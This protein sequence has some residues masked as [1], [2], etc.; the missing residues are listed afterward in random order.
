[1]KNKNKFYIFDTETTG[2]SKDAQIIGIALMTVTEDEEPNKIESTLCKSD[3]FI[4][5]FAQELHHITKEDIED[6]P[7]FEDTNIFKTLTENNSERNIL[8]AHNISFDIAQLK[9]H[10]I[11]SK[12]TQIDT[13][14]VARAL[15]PKLK[16]HRLQYLRYALKLDVKVDKTHNA[17]A[18]VIVLHALL[19]HLAK[20]ISLQDMVKISNRRSK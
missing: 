14:K 18:D 12:Y 2:L 19:E 17:E 16:C 1:M 20:S 8:A 15:Y 7:Y 4:S 9:M 10:N 3:Q 6:K 11:D 5:Y 13:L